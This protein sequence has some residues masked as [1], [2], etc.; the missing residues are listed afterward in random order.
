MQGAE[1]GEPAGVWFGPGAEVLGFGAGETVSNAAMETVY[2]KLQDPETG[3]RLGSRPAT[4]A[5]PEV[6]L[7]RL[8]AKEPV[9][10]TPERLAE[11][12][13]QARREQR[14]PAHYYDLT[15]SPEKSWSVLYAGLKQAGMDAEAETLWG[16]LVEGYQAGM[17]DLMDRAGYV[18]TG[19]HSGR[20]ADRTSG[21]WEK[22][23]GWV[24]TLWRHHTSRDGDP[25][26]HIHGAVLNRAQIA[27]GRWFA[28]DG[29]AVKNAR[30]S[31]A[32]VMSQVARARASALLG[33]RFT[34]RADGL[35]FEIA[36]V[37]ERLITHM[38]SR[39]RAVEPEAQRL[40]AAYRERYGRE[41]N[42]YE[43]ARMT[44]QAVLNTRPR[45]PAH[46]PQG[47]Q[48]LAQW[49]QGVREEFGAT[50]AE[51][52][53]AVGVQAQGAATEEAQA[54]GAPVESLS[55][56]ERARVIGQ[57]LA[58]VGQKTPRWR[59]D[60]LAAAVG[61]HLPDRVV[62]MRAEAQAQ[63]LH[64]LVD[65]ALAHRSAVRLAADP[66]IP[67]PEG[68]RRVE[69]GRGLHEPP[70]GYDRYTTTDSYEREQRL[71]AAAQRVDAARADAARVEEFLAASTL[72]PDQ[73]AVVREIATSGRRVDV[74]IGAAGVGKSYAL[75]EAARLWAATAHD[76]EVG[77]PR[78]L[79]L[80][81]SEN[82]VRVLER[83]GI[84]RTL[85][86]SKFLDARKAMADNARLTASTRELATLRCGDLVIVDE[87]SMAGAAQLEQVIDAAAAVGAK[88]VLAGDDRQLAAVEDGGAFALLAD[89]V[90]PVRLTEVVR[91]QSGWEGPASLRLRDGDATVV[92]EYLRHGR[93]VS[94]SEEQ[95]LEDTKRS[96]LADHVSGTQS[97]VITASKEQAAELA[98]H[99]RAELVAMGRVEHAGVA[100][101]D[102]T[103]AGVG[104]VIQTRKNEH[105]LDDGNGGWVANRDTYLVEERH[106][107]GS[108]L[109]RRILGVDDLGERRWGRPVRLPAGYVAENVELGYAGT[110]HAA[111]GQTVDRCYAM[112][113]P[114][115]DAY[116]L[117]VAA[118][119]ARERTLLFVPVEQ[120]APDAL[121]QEAVEAAE[122]TPEAVL[123]GI[124]DRPR[125]AESATQVLE[126]EI[127]ARESL[128]RLAP[129]W[130][131][132]ITT[133]AR[134]RYSTQLRGL[135]SEEQWQRLETD[136]AAQALMRAVRAA[137]VAGRDP[138]QL[139]TQVVTCRELDSAES[140]GQ[141]LHHRVVQETPAID[142]AEIAGDGSFVAR[143]LELV[144]PELSGYARAIAE[145]MDARVQVLGDRA[146]ADPPAWT[147]ALGPVPDDPT[148]RWE[149]TRR[150]GVIAG[151]RE[152]HGYRHET[153]AI[154]PAP[155]AG[156]V[157]ER[158][159]W[160]AA[161]TALGRPDE[162][163]D[164]AAASTGE[165]DNLVEAWTRA[166]QD[167]PVNVDTDLADTSRLAVF[168]D[169]EARLT[170]A[171]IDRAVEAGED[172]AALEEQLAQYRG[173]DEAARARLTVLEEAAE[174]RQ[175]WYQATAAER[176]TAE[177]ARQ[178][179]GRRTDRNLTH[180][181]ETVAS[182]P[183]AETS[184]QQLG[185]DEPVAVA[186]DRSEADRGAAQ[187]DR[188]SSR[189]RHLEEE[190]QV[191]ADEDEEP[192]RSGRQH[193]TSERTRD[194]GRERDL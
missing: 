10:P 126:Q 101:H 152:Q 63:I 115:M 74:L 21:R 134:Q 118:T 47:E 158:A 72:R 136:P 100:L 145:A 34:A 112:V 79:G 89:R 6:R 35:G 149:W 194:S 113:D 16:C 7:E 52:P 1:A 41:P 154:G 94:G 2:G 153:D 164:T 148:A 27:D 15:F 95:L 106:E 160:H 165:L 82:A 32:G 75:A 88:V 104:D 147:E 172:T 99:I 61:A 54:E 193:Q 38:S 43:L 29:T 24:A 123:A 25:Q 58:E 80:T 103:R 84:H 127:D 44:Q 18:R 71:V 186:P 86:L 30:K 26:L 109:V 11:L 176:R 3:A 49:E 76:P 42:R 183:D 12:Q 62:A 37:D 179:L 161:W 19:R 156:A 85:N 111:Q 185:V 23:Q 143:T 33:L 188:P 151:Y 90:T 70:A 14:E 59:R 168:V 150:A 93:I 22:A 78:V 133:D 73:A 87:A 124:I 68:W 144:D 173:D 178:E 137:E 51:V 36:G 55:G 132:L 121:G 191:D 190:Q 5:S 120:P 192:A 45:K 117:Y 128:A 53:A 48:L 169:R 162:Q 122:T 107:D 20:I 83:D 13:F 64:T 31:A 114:A 146:A 67:A 98:S 182:Q 105:R 180:E 92:Q 170:Q 102:T 57:A 125:E 46:P 69:D 8:I 181:A 116:S 174:R 56:A 119:R 81:A 142:P 155:L 177:L 140:L 189:P 141:V 129:E 39:T 167:G 96:F 130:T 159:G 135:L 97:L 50:L 139:L 110:V 77:R 66:L 40:A 184:E 65:E 157:D 163:R 4:Y 28:L 131:D 91:F 166:E 187:L 108:L 138:E 9:A 171:E 175:E 60:D 17:S